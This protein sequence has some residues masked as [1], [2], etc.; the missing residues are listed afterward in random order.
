V[1]T[2]TPSRR[3]QS[4]AGATRARRPTIVLCGSARDRV[5][6]LAGALARRGA[7][8]LGGAAEDRDDAQG[9]VA[10]RR[11][12][13][14][15]WTTAKRV[16]AVVICP[17]LPAAGRRGAN[18]AEWL[19]GL[20]ATL[21]P[22]FFLA[23]HALLR[24]ARGGGGAV[25][26]VIPAPRRDGGERV[27][28][29]GMRALIEGLARA[30]PRRARVAAITGAPAPGRGAARVRESAALARAVLALVEPGASAPVLCAFGRPSA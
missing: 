24:L 14:R 3:R 10:S 11:W 1:V 7:R 23:K 4:R 22:T 5:S 28:E 12:M 13:A 19:A 20:D 17:A 15:M 9:D 21:K 8:V 26:A 16:D 30:A 2:R 27:A 18:P 6:A 25:V 29:E